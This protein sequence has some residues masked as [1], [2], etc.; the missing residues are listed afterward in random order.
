MIHAN[1]PNFSLASTLAHPIRSTRAFFQKPMHDGIEKRRMGFSTAMKVSAAVVVGALVIAVCKKTDAKPGPFYE[2][3]SLF[4]YFLMT[5]V[6]GMDGS[7]T[8]FW[9]KEGGISYALPFSLQAK[10][11]SITP[12]L[13]ALGGTTRAEGLP[14]AETNFG[15]LAIT[16]NIGIGRFTFSPGVRWIWCWS[17]PW[18]MQAGPMTF[19]FPGEKYAD[20]DWGM[21]IKWARKHRENGFVRSLEAEA[22]AFNVRQ[23]IRNAYRVF[24]GSVGLPKGW[25][26]EA[27]TDTKSNNVSAGA[28]KTFVWNRGQRMVFTGAGYEFG[29]ES[30]C[31]Y[32]GTMVGPVFVMG[33]AQSEL[34]EK[35]YHAVVSVNPFGIFGS[36]AKKDNKFRAAPMPPQQNYA[37]GNSWNQGR[38]F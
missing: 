19:K 1:K 18:S 36:K 13:M 16:P 31:G 30:V 11:A 24:K 14:P 7:M 35:S 37:G 27:S 26:I 15:K 17:K 38:R 33:I 25:G 32:A 5:P 4:S 29:T 10:G 22:T 20:I 21:R 12:T 8:N 3:T 23:T 34:G 2:N 9:V 6:E 28:N